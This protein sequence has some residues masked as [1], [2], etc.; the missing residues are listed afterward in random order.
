LELIRK[1]LLISSSPKYYKSKDKE[2]RD[3]A[4]IPD[5]HHLCALMTR[6]CPSRR[7]EASMFVASDEATYMYTRAQTYRF[8]KN[9]KLKTQDDLLA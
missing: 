3:C 4:C 1:K 5:V 8:I 2:D 7:I 6:S 9:D